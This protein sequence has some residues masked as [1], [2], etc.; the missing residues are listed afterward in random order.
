MFKG[1]NIK[2]PFEY[3]PDLRKTVC[4]LFSPSNPDFHPH[5]YFQP[6]SIRIILEWR[7]VSW[8]NT[9]KGRSGTP[10]LMA[11]EFWFCTSFNIC[12]KSSVCRP[13]KMFGFDFHISIWPDAIGNLRLLKHASV[14]DR[15]SAQLVLVVKSGRNPFTDGYGAEIVENWRRRIVDNLRESC[16]RSRKIKPNLNPSSLPRKWLITI[17]PP[18]LSPAATKSRR[19]DKSHRSMRCGTS[20]DP[21]GAET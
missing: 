13:P 8:G 18:N 5:A 10:F 2:R 6:V 9:Q 19:V 7:V 15:W 21:G 16:F 12:Y 1:S 20:G 4:K 14:E 3:E 11:C 17:W